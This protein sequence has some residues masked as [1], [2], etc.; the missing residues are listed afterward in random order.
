MA[1]EVQPPRYT[2]I[3]QWSDEDKCYVAS[4]P[5]WKPHAYA[6]AHGETYEEAAKNAQE[7]LELLMEDEFGKPVNAPP[8]HLFRYPGA[9]VVDLPNDSE[10][11]GSKLEDNMRVKKTA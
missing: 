11:D 1:S 4:L 3:I 7:I 6:S 10:D 8:P 9:D 5:E 2:V